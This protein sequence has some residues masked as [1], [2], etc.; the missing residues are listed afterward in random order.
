MNKNELYKGMRVRIE[1]SINTRKAHTV[2]RDMRHMIK[3]N[4]RIQKIINTTTTNCGIAVQIGSYW[5]DPADLVSLEK[6][7]PLKKAEIFTFDV[8]DLVL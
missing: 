1:T 2:N 5:W 4:Y 8:K 6:D 7:I 3:K